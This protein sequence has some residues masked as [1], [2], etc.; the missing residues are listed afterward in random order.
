[1]I[2]QYLSPPDILPCV[3][4]YYSYFLSLLNCAIGV[5][6][7]R[8]IQYFCTSNFF[9]KNKRQDNIGIN[10]L[11]LDEVIS[12]CFSQATAVFQ[13]R[14]NK[15]SFVSALDCILHDYAFFQHFNHVLSDL[16]GSQ[17]V[18]SIF[19][20]MV[21]DWTWDKSIITDY[22]RIKNPVIVSIDFD[23][24]QIF[25]PVFIKENIREILNNNLGSNDKPQIYTTKAVCGFTTHRGINGNDFEKLDW[26][27]WD[28]HLMREQDGA[29]IFWPWDYTIDA[30]A[31]NTLGK[32]IDFRVE[33]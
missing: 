33:N 14:Q 6:T 21:L 29:V 9:K 8:V 17:K 11:E 1:M 10:G 30:L 7:N 3:C 15:M 2:S 28:N 31:L 20:T 13:D 22:F 19:P 16:D 32:K 12:E 26:D 25:F 5:N 4:A 18:K 27:N 24:Y 23:S